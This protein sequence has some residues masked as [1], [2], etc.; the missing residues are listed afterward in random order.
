MS[1]FAPLESLIFIY[2]PPG[3]GKTS[4]GRAL[5]QAL[6]LPFHDLDEAIAERAGT[7]IPDIFREE[8][9]VG[10]RRRER[11]ALGEV[12]ASGKVVVALGGGALL[13]PRSRA[14][15]EASG[16]VITLDAPLDSLAARLAGTPDPRPLLEGDLRGRLESLLETRA[17]H[18]ASFP[19]RVE[20][21]RLTPQ[22]VAWQI[23]VRLGRFFVTGMGM[24]YEARVQAGGLAGVG[25][26]LEA[27]GFTGQPAVL[28][29]DGNVAPLYAERAA[30]SLQ[31]AGFTV[32]T[33][34]IP[35]GEQYK[36]IA[37]VG[38]LWEAFAGARLE[39]SSPVV[40]LG[41]GVACDL[42]GFAAA[43]YLRGVPWAA[44]PTTLLAMADASL[45]GKTGADLPQGKNL[46]G[47]FHPPRLVLADP[48]ALSSLPEAELR[49]GMAEVVKAGLIGDAELFRLCALGWEAVRADWGEVVRRAMAVKVRVIQIDPY[50]KGPRAALNLG[51]TLGHALER[52]TGYRLRH[53]EGVAIGMVAAARLSERLGWAEAGLAGEIEAALRRLD[54]PVEVPPGLDRQAVLEA[55]QLDKK[56]LQGRVRLVLPVRV[57]EW[58]L[59]IEDP[60]GLL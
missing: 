23:Q 24:G 54:L 15:A 12:L 11:A 31:E 2:G 55:M 48:Q 59:E 26:A 28:V 46:I 49:S 60:A 21:S 42:A 35:A 29:S 13:D 44:L 9:E 8:G 53:G 57:G 14:E 34:L 10:F 50:E 52:A 22:E 7:A 1:R 4:T 30:A 20:T 5:A 40:A 17:G 45:G 43:T 18:Y 6:N 47:A 33:I 32:Q 37:T 25:A 27:L 58:R 19:T 41:G 38:R 16:C 3:S 51:Q 56:R 36:T 39:R